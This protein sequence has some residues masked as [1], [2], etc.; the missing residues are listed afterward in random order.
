MGGSGTTTGDAPT[1]LWDKATGLLK[2]PELMKVG[3]GALQGMS[4]QKAAQAQLEY[5]EALR[6]K[7]RDRFNQSILGQTRNY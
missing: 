4:Q 1:S 6:Q 7:E 5:Q 2:N 3:M